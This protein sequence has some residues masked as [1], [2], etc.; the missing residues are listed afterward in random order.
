MMRVQTVAACVSADPLLWMG[1][2][3]GS[4]QPQSCCGQEMA[5]HEHQHA[6][7]P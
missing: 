1:A 5:L 4:K 6:L 3:S 7:A 2:V